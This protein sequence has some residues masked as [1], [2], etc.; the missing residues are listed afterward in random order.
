MEIIMK[1]NKYFFE[2]YAMDIPFDM[3]HPRYVLSLDGVDE[4]LETITTN[5]PYSLTIDDFDNPD[6]VQALLHIDVL[7][8]KNHQLAMAVPFFLDKDV[9]MLKELS[10]Q[11][12]QK[13][14]DE[15]ISHKD[16]MIKIIHKIDNGF[17]YDRNLYHI[18]CGY[19]FDGRMFDYL[20]ENKWVTTS[21]IHES[22]YDYLVILYEDSPRLNEYSNMLLC[23]YNRFVK[24][25]QGFV[26][27]GDSMGNRK[28]FYRYMRL[29]E[30]NQ[31]SE[32]E[33]NYMNY[34]INEY[35]HNFEKVIDGKEIDS[36]FMEIFEYFE[37]CDHNKIIVPIYYQKDETIKE[38]LYDFVL[39]IIKD[40]IKDALSMM[41]YQNK[42]CAF[43]HDVNIKDI[44]NEIYHLIF[45]EINELLVQKGLVSNPSY[46]EGQGRFFRSFER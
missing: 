22:G 2:N 35:I 41:N 8:I 12:A 25:N 45:G 42:L 19:I 37:Y 10:K 23:S 3:N 43:S 9:E 7:Q 31:L 17:S 39:E 6:L 46:V 34:S 24:N 36:L 28:D 13:I 21:L 26:S 14:T 32:K 11:A 27:F 44:A 33:M 5:E 15:L 18:L 29:K 1:F 16:K 4:I 38:E 20:E 40:H 30:L